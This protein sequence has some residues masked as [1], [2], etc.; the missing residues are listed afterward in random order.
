MR[1]KDSEELIECKRNKE[2]MKVL[3]NEK[4]KTKWNERDKKNIK[5]GKWLSWAEC[6]KEKKILAR[7]SKYLGSFALFAIRSDMRHSQSLYS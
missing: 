5:Q 1:R 6:E 3:K 7:N 2:S 4:K